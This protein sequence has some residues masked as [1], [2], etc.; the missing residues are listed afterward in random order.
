MVVRVKERNK[1]DIKTLT[2]THMYLC[3]L[4]I[5]TVY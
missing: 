5:Y 2:H 1:K 4:T 3:R